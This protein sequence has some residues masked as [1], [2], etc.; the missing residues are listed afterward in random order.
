MFVSI[1]GLKV[2]NHIEPMNALRTR[3]LLDKPSKMIGLNFHTIDKTPGCRDFT[4]LDAI[5]GLS[6]V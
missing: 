4:G 2:T 1:C 5:V 3:P 6:I